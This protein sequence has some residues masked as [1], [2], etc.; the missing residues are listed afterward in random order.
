MTRAGLEQST[1]PSATLWRS[2]LYVPGDR[3]EIIPKALNSASDCVVIDLED[4]VAVANKDM[5]RKNACAA[6]RENPNSHIIVR[7]NA[8]GSPWHERDIAALSEAGVKA[9]RIP[10]SETADVVANIGNSLGAEC[11][12]HLLIESARGLLASDDLAK[13]CATVRSIALGEADLKSDLGIIDDAY[14]SYARGKIIASARA[15]GLIAPTQSVYTNVKDD[16]GLRVTSQQARAAGFFGRSVIHP[17]QVE[18]VNAVYTPSLDEV[19]SAQ[20]VVSALAKSDNTSA[21]ILPDGR[22]VDPAIA[23]MAVRVL[24]L[25]ATYGTTQEEESV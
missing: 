11:E 13:A 14:L 22:F 15:A 16:H 8:V 20:Q 19:E 12:L 17:G 6:V 24:D 3:G 9:V 25:A 2:W 7:I 1:K 4:A 10:K 23:A 18:I 21:L 5:A